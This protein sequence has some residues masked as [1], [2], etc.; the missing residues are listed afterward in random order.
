MRLEAIGM[1]R[2]E[3]V[4]S[5]VAGSS[6]RLSGCRIWNGTHV[7]RDLVAIDARANSAQQGD[8][9]PARQRE[10]LGLHACSAL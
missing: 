6:S 5:H 2:A 7:V 8:G 9:T 4:V 3:V 1:D 10:E